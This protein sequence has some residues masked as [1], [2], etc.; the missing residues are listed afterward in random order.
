MLRPPSPLKHAALGALVLTVGAAAPVLGAS[1][2]HAVGPAVFDQRISGSDRYATAVA[3]SR[4]TFNAGSDTVVI[5]A[6]DAVVDGL[7]ASYAAGAAGAPILS[8]ARDEV[9][10]V[11]AEEVRRLKAT[12][13]IVVGGTAA[14]GQGV[15]VS[16]ESAG[17]TVTRLAGADRY[18]TA[19]LVATSTGGAPSAAFIASGDSPADA[20]ALGPI[21]YAQEYPILLTRAEQA[22]SATTS[23]LATLGGASRI[24]VGGTARVSEATATALGSSQRLSGADRA[25]TAIAIADWAVETQSFTPA[26]VALASGRDANAVDALT[27]SPVTGSGRI[28]VLFTAGDRLGEA[29]TASL[30]ERADRLTG[31][32]LVLGGASAVPEA[33]VAGAAAAAKAA[34]GSSPSSKE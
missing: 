3:A 12:K 22:P 17:L 29:T 14:V 32:S 26:R 27:S 21:A 25:R 5:V 28:P 34:T 9:L 11:T 33:V 18:E 13:A 2:A 24:V 16:L 10:P 30:R 4:T 7:T 1:A 20:L 31:S 6:G 15:T 8:V 23:A 19:A